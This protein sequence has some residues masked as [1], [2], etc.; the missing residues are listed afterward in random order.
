M[1]KKAKGAGKKKQAKEDKE[2]LPEV[3]KE[4]YEIQITDL[5]QKLARL[6]SR[7]NE[8]ESE[9]E[10]VKKNLQ[11]LDEDRAD[12]IAHLKRTLQAKADEIA[13]L[14]ERL[15]ALQQ[16]RETERAMFL[17]KIKTM[18]HDFKSMHEQLNSEIKLLNGK[19]NSLEEF[20]REREDL[21]NKFLKQEEAMEEQ[22]KIHKVQLYEVERKFIIGKDELKKDMESKLLQLSL[23]FQNT[24]D[25]R[26]ATTTHRVIRENVAINNEINLLMESWKFLHDENQNLKSKEK[27]FKIEAEIQREENKV[28]LKKNAVQ[29]KIIDKISKLHNNVKESFREMEQV[30]RA[31]ATLEHRLERATA[32]LHT[33]QHESQQ[34]RQLLHSRQVQ[35]CQHEV[36]LYELRQHCSHLEHAVNTAAQAVRLALK[37]QDDPNEDESYNLIQRESLL[38]TLLELFGE[39]TLKKLDSPKSIPSRETILLSDTITAYKSGDL[40]LVCKT[41]DSEELLPRESTETLKSSSKS[42]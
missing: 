20:R 13:E 33:E 5:N 23:D 18:E 11:K 31:N 19:L 42:K 35:E 25:I 10:E 29:N 15:V 27:E 1:G 21:M 22:E 7:C 8:V 39:T 34:L 2:V 36:E 32:A 4:F 3:D 37:V 12:I 28:L 9:N 40:G 26:I 24:T 38:T 14:Q 30:Q 16:A 17:E 6:R 41:G